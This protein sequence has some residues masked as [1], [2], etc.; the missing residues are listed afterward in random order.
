MK[1]LRSLQQKQVDKQQAAQK[2]AK[3]AQPVKST[4]P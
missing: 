4:K 1:R 3:L 2:Q